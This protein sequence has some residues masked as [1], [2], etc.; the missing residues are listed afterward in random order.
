MQEV[1]KKRGILLSISDEF[2]T[3]KDQSVCK[4]E[5]IPEYQGYENTHPE[6]SKYYIL[7]CH[8]N[9]KTIKIQ[10]QKFHFCS[11]HIFAGHN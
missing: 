1:Q 10:Y 9:E 4:G 8:I 11:D 7:P 2:S 3:L 6:F 5:S